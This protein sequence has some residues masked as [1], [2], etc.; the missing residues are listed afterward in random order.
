MLSTGRLR[1]DDSSSAA[2]GS[3]VD[4]AGGRD[5][6]VRRVGLV[7]LL[8]SLVVVFAL[9]VRLPDVVLLPFLAVPVVAAATF[10][11][12]RATTL[13]GVAAVALGF[14]TGV[15]DG[16]LGSDDYWVRLAGLLVVCFV[17]VQLS[18]LATARELA[19]AARERRYRLLADNA[20]DSVF[21]MDRSWIIS[22]ASPTVTSELGYA[23]DEL[24]GR[25]RRDLVDVADRDATV[26]HELRTAAGL[27]SQYEERFV[28][29]SGA[30]RWMSVVL[31]PFTDD[32]GTVTGYVAALRDIDD[33]V[34]FRHELDR[35]E[36]MFRLA[37]AG[38]AEGMAVVGPDGR[39]VEVNDVLGELVGRDGAWLVEHVEEDLFPAE[40]IPSIRDVRD[41]LRSGVSGRESHPR[42]LLR[43]DGREIWI[44]HAIG[45]VRDDAGA[46]L[47]YVCQY[48]DVTAAHVERLDLAGRVNRDALTGVASR[49]HLLDVLTHTDWRDRRRGMGVGL[50]YCDIDHFKDIND[51]WGHAVGD[52]VLRIV[53]DRIAVTVRDGD[54]VGRMGG[55]EFV[56]VLRGV[57]G[58]EDAQAVAEKIRAAVVQP[59]SAGGQTVTCSLSIGISLLAHGD[60]LKDSLDHADTALYASKREGRDR[61]SVY[62]ALVR[63]R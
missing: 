34:T 6:T 21:L 29:A 53:A 15:V 13:V 25:H 32:L 19:L 5:G 41:R 50:L 18:R 59:I 48:Q 56:V 46:P 38:A 14:A 11:P 35:R 61:A 4:R 54:V 28:L 63:Q 31:N 39:L 8:L 10:L 27:R 49:S 58:V 22:W 40:A 55:D 1:R 7:L 43:A 12:P 57:R 36:R 9:D 2:W 62:D 51:T 42:R 33:E 17:A 52:D 3:S 24:L 26:Q 60:S 47:F 37:M 30:S 20:T 45:L 23:V 44:N 16:G